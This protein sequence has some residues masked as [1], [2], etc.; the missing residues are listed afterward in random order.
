MRIVPALDKSEIC[1]VFRDSGSAKFLANE[2]CVA[3][4]SGHAVSD[5]ILR[6]ARKELQVIVDTL[7][8][9]VLVNREH[10]P[11]VRERSHSRGYCR[12]WDERSRYIQNHRCCNW[13]V[14]GLR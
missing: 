3:R 11:G 10:W 8:A 9:H 1:N 2:G 6:A 7:M 12:F 14:G 5:V 13:H 4:P